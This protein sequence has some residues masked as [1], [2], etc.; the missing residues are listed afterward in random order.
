MVFISSIN[1]FWK[2]EPLFII[3]RKIRKNK[4]ISGPFI[5]MS[6]PKALIYRHLATDSPFLVKE[7][8]YGSDYI[9]LGIYFP[10]CNGYSLT[11]FA[12]GSLSTRQVENRLFFRLS[13]IHM[14]HLKQFF[15]R[16]CMQNGMN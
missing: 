12:E 11:S 7:R 9:L 10:L 4:N 8:L 13:A 14:R 16:F 6:E 15:W 3:Q 2:I 5:S 1:Y